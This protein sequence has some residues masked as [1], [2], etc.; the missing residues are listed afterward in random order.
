MSEKKGGR[1]DCRPRIFKNNNHPLQ[2]G[3]CSED[4][5]YFST[6]LEEFSKKDEEGE[7]EMK[8]F[9]LSHNQD[10]GEYGEDEED[11]KLV[12]IEDL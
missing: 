6:C 9:Y 5:P 11:L 1:C 3:V 10:F 4:C 12:E 7:E 2:P 8:S